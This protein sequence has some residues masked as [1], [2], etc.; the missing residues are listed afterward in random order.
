MFVSGG[1]N[2]LKW[3]CYIGIISLIWFVIGI[4]FFGGVIDLF[5]EDIVDIDIKM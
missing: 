4:C 5:I 2:L 3:G 1:Y